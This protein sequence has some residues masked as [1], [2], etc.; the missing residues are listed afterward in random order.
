VRLQVIAPRFYVA[1]RAGRGQVGDKLARGD[2]VNV[3][4]RRGHKVKL[5]AKGRF[6]SAFVSSPVAFFTMEKKGSEIQIKVSRLAA[7]G[8]I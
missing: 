6:Q 5:Q 7:K 4:P 1:P 8:T 3:V 2:G